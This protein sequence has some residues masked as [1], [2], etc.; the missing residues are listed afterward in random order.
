[1]NIFNEIISEK[2]W[3]L[4][5]RYRYQDKIIDQTVEDTWS[6][7]AGAVAKAEHEQNRAQWQQVFYD[8]LVGLDRKNVV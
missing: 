4:K 5:Y 6:R 7:V 8:A 2:V 1:M 3:D